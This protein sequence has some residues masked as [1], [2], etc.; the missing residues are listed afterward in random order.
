MRNK[1]SI[2][3]KPFDPN[4]L[5]QEDPRAYIFEHQFHKD[6]D[7]QDITDSMAE[8]LTVGRPEL[9]F[10]LRLQN[11]PEFAKYIISAA[12]NLILQDPLSYLF[13]FRLHKKK[14][15][16]HLLPMLFES[17]SKFLNI[18]TGKEYSKHPRLFSEVKDIVANIA[19]FEPNYYKMS[20]LDSDEIFN[21]APEIQINEKQ[22][23][24]QKEKTETQ[25]SESSKTA[26]V[27]I[28]GLA[29]IAAKLESNDIKKAASIVED[30][31]EI[32]V[33]RI[34]RLSC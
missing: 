25:T 22:I 2:R 26:L 21:Q 17:L 32:I 28:R 23:K 30:A 4:L 13:V 11:L 33:N 31:T 10:E 3:Y 20:G 5:S 29:K 19:K 18:R 7:F 12:K 6:P 27:I 9:F 15:L 34:G 1:I 16:R 8:K 14:A 24:D